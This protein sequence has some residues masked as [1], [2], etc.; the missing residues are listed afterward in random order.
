MSLNATVTLALARLNDAMLDL[1][2][3]MDNI[4]ASIEH[5][6]YED[7]PSRAL[8]T[9]HGMLSDVLKKGAETG[10]L[11]LAA[12]DSLEEYHVRIIT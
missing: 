6:E 2:H 9:V 10:T 11:A 1:N 8:Q 4:S 12:R 3:C 7:V 5:I